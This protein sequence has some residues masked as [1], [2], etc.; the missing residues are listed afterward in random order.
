MNM[1]AL[2]MVGTVM[3]LTGAAQNPA[4]AFVTRFYTLYIKQN[5]P[6]F[7]LEGAA[8]R[9][10]DPLLSTRLRQQLDDAAACQSDWLRQQPKGSTDK[11]PFADCC[12][13]SSTPDGMPTSFLVGPTEVLPDGRY[14]TVVDFVRKEHR[15]LI[16]WRDALIVMKEGDRFVVDDVVYDVDPGSGQGRLSDSFHDCR[17]RRWVGADSRV[18]R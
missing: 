11:P 10:L 17:G 5:P 7:F 16:K 15:D 1:K 8:K 12:L 18:T 2:A 6:G 4:Q 9:A 13:F 14:R 3:L